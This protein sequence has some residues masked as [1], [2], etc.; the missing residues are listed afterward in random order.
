MIKFETTNVVGWEATTRGMRNP[1]NSWDKSDSYF[2]FYYDQNER[3]I[4]YAR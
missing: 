1:M 3:R 4:K 2:G